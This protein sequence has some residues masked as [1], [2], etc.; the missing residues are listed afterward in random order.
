MILTYLAIELG[1]NTNP[2]RLA[3]LCFRYVQFG[4]I[5][6]VMLYIVVVYN[7][8]AILIFNKHFLTSNFI[9]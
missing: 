7:N 1:K 5:G 2:F 3:T 8:T 6:L 9:V 4:I